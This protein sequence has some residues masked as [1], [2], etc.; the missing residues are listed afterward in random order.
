MGATPIW[1]F[2]GLETM[3]FYWWFVT[4]LVCFTLSFLSFQL[5]VRVQKVRLATCG[6]PDIRPKLAYLPSPVE[7]VPS[8]SW[9]SG[10]QNLSR[11]Y[12][13]KESPRHDGLCMR[14]HPLYISKYQNGMSCGVY[15][16][17]IFIFF[18]EHLTPISICII[19]RQMIVPSSFCV[20]I[21]K[22]V[23]GLGIP[24]KKTTNCKHDQRKFSSLNSVVRTVKMWR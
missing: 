5:R 3:N 13:H 22:R 23:K 16:Y 12:Q 9:N 17:V 1:P 4:T 6:L 24:L 8:E 10:L 7:R 20:S 2:S 14:N 19:P 21:A 18:P 15:F 11:F